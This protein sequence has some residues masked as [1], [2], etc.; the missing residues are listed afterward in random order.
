[1]KVLETV[2]KY[3]LL[4]NFHKV[5][6]SV[7]GGSDSMALLHFFNV[8]KKVL[9]ISLICVN[10]EHGIRGEDSVKDS[11]F[12]ESYCKK[13]NIEFLGF[14]VDTLSFKNENKY[15]VEQAARILRYDIYKKIIEDKTADCV[16][17]AHNKSDRTE[18][19][20]LNLF[21][22][23]GINGIIM[24]FKRDK[25]IRPLMETT[26]EEILKYL[27]D[28]KIDYVTDKTNYDLE[29]SRN[30]IRH[31]IMPKVIQKFPDAENALIRFSDNCKPEN[32]YLYRQ[33]EKYIKNESVLKFEGIEDCLLTRAVFLTLKN[34]GMPANIEAVHIEAIKN[35]YYTSKAGAKINLPNK[36]VC[37]KD[38]DKI[39]FS[40][41]MET[42]AEVIPF[43]LGKINFCGYSINTSLTNKMKKNGALYLKNNLPDNTVFRTKKDND[44]FKKYGGGTKSLGD[45]F[46]DIKLEKRFR[47]FVPLL[48]AGSEII[49][50]IPY[51]ISENY[52]VENFDE[53]FIEINF[54]KTEETC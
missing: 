26:K 24:D 44:F 16:A 4:D 48:A 3:N 50:A 40:K 31:E 18:G 54:K 42:T 1:M 14:N 38:Y 13:N 37:Y 20:L 46:T 53:V 41:E 11:R 21:R 35:L 8:N 28:N 43:K 45:F 19:I 25:I 22:G 39:T 51:N 15:T 47:D 6:V 9:N 7:S 27:S 10:I 34:I 30:F 23:S 36:I 5:A 49:A 29:Y 52:K 32:D 12:V 2:K 17:T 33:A